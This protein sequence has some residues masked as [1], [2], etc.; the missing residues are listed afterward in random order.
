MLTLKGILNASVKYYG[1]KL[2]GVKVGLGKYGEMPQ[3]TPC[4]LLYFEPSEILTSA[5]NYIIE[6]KAKIIAFCCVGGKETSSESAI[7]AFELSEKIEKEFFAL[8]EYFNNSGNNVDTHIN[9]VKPIS[10]PKFDQFYAD[11]AVAYYEF[12]VNYAPSYL[13]V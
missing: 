10:A 11:I 12:E 8:E 2:P 4:V 13:E 5:N 9:R 1:D 7:E 3:E 6:R